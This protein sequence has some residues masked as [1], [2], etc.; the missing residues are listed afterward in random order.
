[1]LPSW[2]QF[3]ESSEVLN[4]VFFALPTF[5]ANTTPLIFGG[6][7]PMDFRK[8][9]FDKKRILGD[10]KTIR[11]FVAGFMCFSHQDQPQVFKGH[12]DR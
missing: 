7:I 9:W 12:E 8:N 10:N 1:M 2:F 11:G 3:I 5:L 6:G 4:A